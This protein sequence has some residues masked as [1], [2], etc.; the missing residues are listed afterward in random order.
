MA[1]Y[2]VLVLR[3]VAIGRDGNAVLIHRW[4]A[5]CI[6]DCFAV[7]GHALDEAVECAGG[8]RAPTFV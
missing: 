2:A 5:V 7:T 3:V 1:T 8:Q 6:N 4:V